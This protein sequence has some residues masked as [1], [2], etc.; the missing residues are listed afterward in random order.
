MPVSWPDGTERRLSRGWNRRAQPG[1]APIITRTIAHHLVVTPPLASCLHQHGIVRGSRLL[2]KPL[3]SRWPPGLYTE[4]LGVIGVRC[5][6]SCREPIIHNGACS[7]RLQNADGSMPSLSAAETVVVGFAHLAREMRVCHGGVFAGK[8][9]LGG[10]PL[11]LQPRAQRDRREMTHRG[12]A[13]PGFDIADR[14]LARLYAVE[15]IAQVIRAVVKLH[16]IAGFP[17]AL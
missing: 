8:F 14:Q 10:I 13:M 1:H 12:G 2:L 17:K 9:L 3:A 4:R 11:Q 5:R 6:S 16:C 7:R 15:E